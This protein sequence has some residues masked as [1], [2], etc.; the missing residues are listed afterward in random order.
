M[1]L[2]H[3][4]WSKGRVRGSVFAA[5]VQNAIKKGSKLHFGVLPF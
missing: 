1:N 3:C 5:I 4:I 2:L